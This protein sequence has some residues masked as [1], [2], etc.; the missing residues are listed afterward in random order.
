M[1]KIKASKP[2]DAGEDAEK[3][4]NSHYSTE[5]NIQRETVRDSSGSLWKIKHTIQELH[6]LAFILQ[7]TDVYTPNIHRSYVNK[8]S[9]QFYL[10]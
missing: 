8:R 7:K 2:P 1:A 6:F 4:G 9:Q 10:Y 3:T 5:E